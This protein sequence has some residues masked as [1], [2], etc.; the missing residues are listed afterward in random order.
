MSQLHDKCPKGMRPACKIFE[1]RYLT[2]LDTVFFF[3]TLA[4]GQGQKDVVCDT[5]P[6]MYIQCTH[7]ILDSYPKR[8]TELLQ[9]RPILN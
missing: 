9:A 4:R 8:N 5:D 1:E 2:T 7:Q 6:K 3:K